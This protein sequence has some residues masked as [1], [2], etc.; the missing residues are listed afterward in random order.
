MTVIETVVPTWAREVLRVH[1]VS[2]TAA[3]AGVALWLVAVDN[4][5]FWRTFAGAQSA[6]AT[7]IGA[8]I[9]LAIVL[10]LVATFVLRLIGIARLAKPA[11]VL[12]L[13]AS[14]LAAHFV[15]GWGVLLDKAMLRNA[16]Q[17]DMREAADLVT[18]ALLVDVLLRG[19]LPAA[20]VLLLPLRQEQPLR[21]AKDVALLGLAASAALAASLAAFY[22]SYASTFRNHRELRLQLVPSNYLGGLYNVLRPR[23]EMPFE[24]VA[25]DARRTSIARPLLMVLVVGETARADNFSLG[26]YP[27]P[28]NAALAGKPLV[29]FSDVTSCGTDT[30]TSL[31]CMFSDLGAEGF[32][33][34]AAS[35]R[36]NVLDVLHKTGVKVQWIENNSGCKGVCDRVPNSAVQAAER[37]NGAFGCLDDALVRGL[38]RQ[39]PA[40]TSDA[41]VVLHQ[42]GSHGPAYFKR[43]PSPGRFEPTCQTNRLQ[44]CKPQEVINAYDNSIAYTTEVLAKLVNELEQRS[45]GRDAVL[46]YVSDHGESLGERGVFL[47]GMPRWLAPHEQSHVPMLLWMNDGARARLAPDSDCLQ[48]V[49]RQP[50]SH[51]HLFHTLLGAFGVTTRAYVPALD[52]FAPARGQLP[53]PA[54]PL[55]TPNHPRL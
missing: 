15:D 31:P 32:S 47:H 46:M 33:P 52:A 50:L 30:A 6:S 14:A 34:E 24:V 23:R 7:A 16:L 35:R 51:D 25:P 10:W 4:F 28:T 9:A 8:S 39:W 36:E 53:C 18:F 2:R 45:A 21:S 1:V 37:C 54:L 26:G 19:M 48:S 42:Q 40:P 44:D 27:R 29:Y 43:Y 3:A 12:L 41:L 17:T 5:S 55:A 22:P 20:V 11:W 49:A 38:I 13:L